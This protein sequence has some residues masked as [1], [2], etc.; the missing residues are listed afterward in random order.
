MENDDKEIRGILKSAFPPV[1]SAPSRDL[2]PEVLRRFDQ[3]VINTP[4]YDW[5]MLALLVCV[6]FLFPGFIPVLLYH[7]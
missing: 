4:W 7:L 5:A 2:W 6:L 1:A 3:R